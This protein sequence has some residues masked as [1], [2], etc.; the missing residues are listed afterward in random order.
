MSF[1]LPRPTNVNTRADVTMG[2][3]IFV[4]VA[5]RENPD[6]VIL[7]VRVVLEDSRK[8]FSRLG[9]NWQKK[10]GGKA[11]AILHRYPDVLPLYAVQRGICWLGLRKMYW[12]RNDDQNQQAA[13]GDA[14]P[15][16]APIKILARRRHFIPVHIALQSRR[17]LS[18]D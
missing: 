9:S 15:V 17:F 12:N 5:F 11:N 8:L 10:V 13:C 14:F 1:A 16:P 6:V 7:A 3:K 2:Y 18:S 4:D